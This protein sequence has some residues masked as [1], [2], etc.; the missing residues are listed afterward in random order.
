MASAVTQAAFLNETILIS[1]Q[2]VAMNSPTCSNNTSSCLSGALPSQSIQQ[3]C[4]VHAM[5]EWRQDHKLAGAWKDDNEETLLGI[6]SWIHS[7]QTGFHEVPAQKEIL[8]YI[9]HIC[10]ITGDTLH[11]NISFQVQPLHVKNFRPSRRLIQ[12]RRKALFEAPVVTETQ[13]STIF[14]SDL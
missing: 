14:L 6:A 11:S 10:F 3:G 13:V 12:D 4:W 7:E 1:K 2:S 9:C 5:C 8:K